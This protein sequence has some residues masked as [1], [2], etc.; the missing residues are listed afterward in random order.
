VLIDGH[1]HAKRIALR[2]TSDH[3][4]EPNAARTMALVGLD[5]VFTVED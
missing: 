1:A 2:R 4:L 5:T 3:H